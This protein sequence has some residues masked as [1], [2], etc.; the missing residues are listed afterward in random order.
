MSFNS[1]ALS[2]WWW[3]LKD[4]LWFRDINVTKLIPDSDKTFQST[5]VQWKMHRSEEKVCRLSRV[6]VAVFTWFFPFACSTFNYELLKLLTFIF[7]LSKLLLM[8]CL[9]MLWCFVCVWVKLIRDF[10]H[11][12]NEV[13]R[14]RLRC[15]IN[16]AWAKRRWKI[17]H[18][19]FGRVCNFL[20]W[21][22]AILLRKVQSQ[23]THLSSHKCA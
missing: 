7:Y 17:L 18:I 4:I 19:K 21:T 8:L 1:L 20:Q 13:A 6:D 15:S 22:D 23:E 12:T 16:D 10:H 2:S 3:F 14:D 5:A 9:L 11:T